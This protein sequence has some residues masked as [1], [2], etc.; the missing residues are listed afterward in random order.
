MLNHALTIAAA[1]C[2]VNMAS[3]R[4]VALSLQWVTTGYE[5]VAVQG[6]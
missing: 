5:I 4:M 3:P 1:L 6:R 2:P